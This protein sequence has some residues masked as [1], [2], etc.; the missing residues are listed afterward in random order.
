MRVRKSLEE[1]MM[2]GKS[3][4]KWVDVCQEGNG[5]PNN[6]FR[7]LQEDQ[8]NIQGRTVGRAEVGGAQGRRDGPEPEFG[9]SQSTG[10]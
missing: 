8:N 6:I 9:R 7:K 5:K 3:L 10:S 4:E 1:T 2:S